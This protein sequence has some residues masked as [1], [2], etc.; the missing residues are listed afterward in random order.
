MNALVFAAVPLVPAAW[1]ALAA[2]TGAT[3]VIH[4]RGAVV[5][6]RQLRTDVVGRRRLV[7]SSAAVVDTLVLAGLHRLQMDFNF[8]VT[9]SI[10]VFLTAADD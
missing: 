1:L 10:T 5:A 4:G 9:D 8:M 3:V 6:A 7:R 2:V